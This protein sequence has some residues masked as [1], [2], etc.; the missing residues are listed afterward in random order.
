M[1][2]TGKRFLGI[3]CISWPATL[4]ASM[5]SRWAS[6]T[7]SAPRTGEKSTS[8]SPTFPR[9]RITLLERCSAR[10]LRA[11]SSGVTERA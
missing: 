1:K 3:G 5:E 6:A 9:R 2:R 8:G 11:R 7:A 4:K 10:S